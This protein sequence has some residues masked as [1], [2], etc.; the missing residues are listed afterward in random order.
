MLSQGRAQQRE[1][2]SQAYIAH[3][4]GTASQ[5]AAEAIVKLVLGKSTPVAKPAAAPKPKQNYPVKVSII[6]PTYN[7]MKFLPEALQS[8]ANQ[9]FKNY[10][11][12]IV[13]DGSSDGTA[14]YLASIKHDK[15]RI[16]TKTNGG[17]PAALNTGFAEMRG[18]YCTWTSSDNVVGPAWLEELVKALDE[19]PEG[20]GYALSHYALMNDKGQILGVDTNQC[21]ETQRMLISNGNASFMYRSDIARQAGDHDVSL[22]GAEDMDMWLRMSQLTR[23][24]L[25]ESVLYFYRLHEKSMTATI[26]KKVADAT[27][28][29]IEKFIASCGGSVDVTRIFP[30]IATSADPALSRWQAQIWLAARFAGSAFWPVKPIID[31]LKSALSARYESV[32]VGNIVL[33]LVRM[34]DWAGAAEII[35]ICA[36]NDQSPFLR[37][38]ADIVTRQ[39]KAALDKI[40][41]VSLPDA[42]LSF[43][44]RPQ[45]SRTQLTQAN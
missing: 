27:T 38:L 14:E 21:F 42:A 18:E 31:L 34:G 32:L 36:Q 5:V 11:L 1:T 25:V 9:T 15:F 16:I 44:R 8:I 12:I 3:R 33:L 10:E 28:R 30:G 13:N 29:M 35:K 2:W 45:Y 39:D 26:P 4:D 24:V 23:G 37:N 22:T 40:P 17:L 43:D 20:V 41:F 7:D 19:A 6:L